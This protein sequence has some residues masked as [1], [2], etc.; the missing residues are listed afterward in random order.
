MV[1]PLRRSDEELRLVNCGE[2]FRSRRCGCSGN[3][4]IHLESCVDF[5]LDCCCR[6]IFVGDSLSSWAERPEQTCFLFYASTTHSSPAKSKL[7]VDLHLVAHRAKLGRADTKAIREADSTIGFRAFR[8]LREMQAM[9]SKRK[10]ALRAAVTTV[11]RDSDDYGS[12]YQRLQAF[13]PRLKLRYPTDS[14]AA[15][16]ARRSDSDSQ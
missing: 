15:T 4:T 6:I 12:R 11:S 13:L 7:T 5:R 14:E 16:I 3:R 8:V 2:S 1:I 9:P 10:P